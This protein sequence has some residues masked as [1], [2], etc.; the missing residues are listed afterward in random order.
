MPRR[1]QLVSLDQ[2]F[3]RTPPVRVL[4]LLLDPTRY[5]AWWPGV[6]SAGD[7]TFRLPVIGEVRWAV[8]DVKEGVGAVVGL[9]GRGMRGHLQW[10]VDPFRDGSI[11]YAGTV[12]E[13]AGGWSDRRMLRYRASLRKGLLSLKTGLETS[14]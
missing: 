13:P 4:E 14:V 1:K 12:L 2:G 3:V 10:H 11:V 5:P 7:G 8:R 9:E 6:S